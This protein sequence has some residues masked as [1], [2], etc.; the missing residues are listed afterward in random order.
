MKLKW[1]GVC[2]VC[3]LI[4]GCSG[5]PKK[6][7][8]TSGE[9]KGTTVPTR[10]DTGPGE[11]APKDSIDPKGVKPPIPEMPKP[12]PERFVIPKTGEGGWKTAAVDGK[13]LAK[14]IGNALASLQGIEGES[15]ATIKTPTGNGQVIGKVKVQNDKSFSIQYL[16]VDK[17]PAIKEVRSNGRLKST[18]TPQGAFTSKGP[19]T[20]KAPEA[21]LTNTQLAEN[22]PR[23]FPQLVFLGLTDGK[24]PWTPL[25]D[26]LLSGRAGFKTEIAERTL[27]YQGKKWSNYRLTAK[28]TAAAAKKYGPCEME[29]VFDGKRYL[30]VTIRVNFKDPKEGE[31]QILWQTGWNFQ[32]KFEP[33]EFAL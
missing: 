22:W 18:S 5:G 20:A 25:I 32:K 3:A 15:V 28:R 11:P 2:S 21:K 29:M 8:S 17:M 7:A 26:E 9:P 24:D 14:N 33:A 30:P 12:D 6:T 19:I 4:A 10:P 23:K 13:T 27:N 1:I 16:V 31:Y